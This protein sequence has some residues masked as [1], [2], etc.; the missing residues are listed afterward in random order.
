VVAARRWCVRA[1]PEFTKV[2]FGIPWVG[3]YLGAPDGTVLPIMEHGGDYKGDKV[4]GKVDG[5]CPGEGQYELRRGTRVAVDKFGLRCAHV[6]RKEGS[7][8][9]DTN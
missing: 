4:D 9:D 7:H 2:S 6:M 1:T 3:S 5:T 8:K